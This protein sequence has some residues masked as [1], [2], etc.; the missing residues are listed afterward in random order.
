MPH[1]ITALIVPGP[2]HADAA[3]KWDL[4]PVPLRCDLTMFHVTHY[5]T[6]YWQGLLRVT[7][8]FELAPSARRLLF[9]TENVIGVLA[10]ELSA[11]LEPAFAL[12][13][14]DYFAGM[15]DQGAVVSIDGGP[16]RPVADINDALRALGVTAAEG[17]DEFDTVG[18]GNHR[19]TPDYLDR[20]VDLCEEIGA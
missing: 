16:I 7:G 11:Q 6:A 9:P 1:S 12:V 20:Y 17:L 3:D 13:V 8:H 19:S 18:L 15:G 5:Y 4:L 14:T 2:Y 10:R